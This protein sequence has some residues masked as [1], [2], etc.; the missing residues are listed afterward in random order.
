MVTA[1]ALLV[2]AEAIPLSLEA[3]RSINRRWSWLRRSVP[4]RIDLRILCPPLTLT[5]LSDQ[6]IQ[7]TGDGLLGLAFSSINTV[8]DKLGS[9]EPAATPVE[10]MIAQKDIPTESQ[11]FTSAFY[12]E[13]DQNPDS[14][15]TFGYIDRDLVGD[16]EIH[17]T[18]IDNSE[19]FWK[20]PS[21]TYS[22]NGHSY[23]QAGNTAIADTGTTLALMS[24]TVCEALYKQIPGATY[25][26]KNQGWVFPLSTKVKDIPN[27]KIDVGGKE[28]LIQAE[29]LAFAP[30]DQMNWYGGVQSRGDLDFDILG[31]TFLKSCYAVSP[32][33]I[34]SQRSKHQLTS[35]YIDLGP[36]QAALRCRSQD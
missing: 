21:T 6:F 20:F 25:D 14:F 13:R 10:N 29:D 24:D 35:E 11:L 7:S 4:P 23:A 12:S 2:L 28:F 34:N 33:L 16:N 5:Q 1:L 9:P 19:G 22:I 26:D 31:D 3:S 27:F 32:F 18:R 36:R 15:Y 17:W 8:K 30:A